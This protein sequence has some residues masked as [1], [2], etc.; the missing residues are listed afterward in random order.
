MKLITLPDGSEVE[1]PDEMSDAQIASVLSGA[2]APSMPV[3]APKPPPYKS[4]I[5]ALDDAVNLVEEGVDLEKV[6]QSFSGLGIKPQD[7]I[8]HGKSRGSEFFRQAPA[9][10]VTGQQV[11][12]AVAARPVGEIKASSY[13]PKATG[14]RRAEDLAREFTGGAISG[15]KG[16]TDVL[17]AGPDNQASALLE[18]A[19]EIALRGRSK[20]AKVSDQIAAGIMQEAENLGLWDQLKAGAEAFAVDPVKSTIQG[21]GTIVPAVIGGRLLAGTKV[22][23]VVGS[24]GARAIGSA[25]TAASAQT[26]GGAITSGAMGLGMAKSQIF[27]TVK[28]DAIESG[29]DADEAEAVAVKAQEYLENPSV[30]FGAGALGVVAGA[31]GAEAVISKFVT[32]AAIKEL[33]KTGVIKGIGTG[34][35]KEAPIEAVQGG[36]EAFAGNVGSRSQGFDV[37]LSRGVGTAAAM[38]GL[39]SAGLGGAAGAA[40]RMPQR[41]DDL[42]VAPADVAQPAQEISFTPP[43]SLASQ[44]GLSPIV[45]PVPTGGANVSRTGDT[46]AATGVGS[47]AGS[48]QPGGSLGV[49]GLDL[50]DAGSAGG[51]IPAGVSAD[52]GTDVALGGFTPQRAAGLARATDTDLLSRAEAA[53]AQQDNNA[54]AQPVEQWFGRKGDGYATEADAAQALPGRQ[55]MF[56]T[57]GWKVEQ[58]PSGKFRLAG[59]EQQGVQ[60]AAGVTTAPAVEQV[61]AMQQQGLAI[62]EQERASQ[63]VQ[64][65]LAPTNSL[66]R[67]ASWV[68]REKATGDVIMETFDRKKVDALNA[69]KYEAVPIQQYLAGLNAKQQE[70]T[71]VD[72]TA[73]AVQGQTQ[74]Q[75]APAAGAEAGTAGTYPW[76]PDAVFAELSRDPESATSRADTQRLLNDWAAR[77]GGK[78]PQLGD[79]DADAAATVTAL[80]NLFG[81]ATGIGRGLVVPY[82]EEG[83]DNGFTMSG[84]AFVN[85]AMDSASVDAPRTALHEIKHVIEQI[86]KADA[87]A[88]RTDTP[89]QQFVSSIDSIFDDMTEAGKRAYVSNFL[90]K[91]ELEAIADPAQREAKLMELIAAPDTR[92]EMVADFFGNRSQDRAF[93]TDLAKADPQGF[94]GF[95]KKWLAVID[96]LIAKLKGGKTQGRKESAKVDQY[97]RDLNK[98]KMVARD[99]L[100][101]FRKGNLGQQAAPA[102]QKPAAPKFSFAGEASK[103]ADQRSLTEAKERIA[104]G[105]SAERVRRDTGWFQGADGKW[106]YEINDK[107]ASVDFAMLGNLQSGGWPAFRA[108]NVSYRDMGDGRMMLS[109]VPVGAKTT[110]EIVS[111]TV[112]DRMLNS[113][114][115]DEILAKVEAGEGRE[116]FVGDFLEAKAIDQE[117]DFDG[118]NALPLDH[119]LDH[120]ALFAAYP[121]LRDV[122]V[123]IDK[124]FSGASFSE[125]EMSDGSVVH[126]IKLGAMPIRGY[127]SSLLHEIQHGIQTIEGFASGGSPTQYKDTNQPLAAEIQERIRAVA[128]VGRLAKQFGKTHKEV[129]QSGAIDEPMAS[130]IL[131]GYT[132][133]KNFAKMVEY[134]ND[135]LLT[136]EEKYRRLAGEVEA[137][138]TQA[139]MNMTDEERRATPPSQTADVA[140]SDV[141]VMFNG[142]EMKNAPMPANAPA[143]S[144]RQEGVSAESEQS[145]V[146]QDPE[147]ISI[148]EG[149]Q[150]RGL[151]AV[152]AKEAAADHPLGE[153]IQKVHNYFY[154]ILDELESA[155]LIEINC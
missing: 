7:I 129:L 25:A 68:I 148:F 76:L 58:M 36:F 109:I 124:K 63:S 93:L 4:R 77:T 51:G 23:Q 98:A 1:F 14:L 118:F 122:M 128:D 106:R 53:V 155:G 107:D 21:A 28:K 105:Q 87:E 2:R 115:P 117:F 66:M 92:S 8:A 22:A 113:I 145:A 79:P 56:P 15:F 10:K 69:K 60:E 119:V 73:Q 91:S 120:K 80:G 9:P 94:E 108:R 65:G 44:A 78:A 135:R 84:I 29:L 35:L 20:E 61:D 154:D 38:E 134:A 132:S 55:R 50:P 72:Q 125:R 52:A 81:D 116:D 40:R 3:E 146:Q 71:N 19:R 153:Q 47:L 32:K 45:V 143:M 5:E 43:D 83:G 151:K 88:G 6:N 104:D 100:V 17:G 31:T 123:Q 34:V 13:T 86:A 152:R 62:P 150:S 26:A 18:R 102:A 89:A 33:A 70:T 27:D 144:P 37:G 67:T 114:L 121:G 127:K 101:A 147:L 46:G 112:P 110:G 99:A 137:R 140:E 42:A 59:Y 96:N 74:G 141:I 142:K 57:L 111:V 149:L 54:N 11:D 41:Q 95:V 130:S 16:I 126:V 64:E 82:R 97:V 85:T 24:A 131:A 30:I 12:A 90:H 49:P 103:T 133:E 139:R 136:P 75:E 39:S 48:D 138:N